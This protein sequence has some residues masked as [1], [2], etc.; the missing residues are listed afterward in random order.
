M[1]ERARLRILAS[2][3]LVPQIALA[4]W[5]LGQ[6]LSSFQDVIPVC[7]FAVFYTGGTLANEGRLASA[8]DPEIYQSTMRTVAA[9]LGKM[10]WLYPPPMAVV[11]QPFA[12]LPYRIGCAIW[13]TLGT[14]GW[15]WAASRWGGRRGVA[16]M[17]VFP[18][19]VMAILYA[20]AALWL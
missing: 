2:I 7:D 14:A 9:D 13:L 4:A 10:F 18:G 8:Y 19:T 16:W 1:D 20:Q 3:V 15:A 17:L 11:S 12:A 6:R 5:L